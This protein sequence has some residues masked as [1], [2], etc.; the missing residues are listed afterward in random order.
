MY[1]PINNRSNESSYDAIDA[2]AI[3]YQ[4]TKKS[5]RILKKEKEERNNRN[6]KRGNENCAFQLRFKTE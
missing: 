5:A 2:I 4:I 1:Y 3:A 6:Y